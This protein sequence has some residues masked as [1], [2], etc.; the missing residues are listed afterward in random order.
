MRSDD[1]LRLGRVGVRDLLPEFCFRLGVERLFGFVEDEDGSSALFFQI[2][3]F[4]FFGFQVE[5]THGR[6]VFF[7]REFLAEPPVGESERRD[8][9][10]PVENVEYVFQRGEVSLTGRL[11]L[12]H[13]GELAG[14]AP[15]S[16]H[17]GCSNGIVVPGDMVG[18]IIESWCTV[19]NDLCSGKEVEIGRPVFARFAPKAVGV[20]SANVILVECAAPEEIRQ[21]V[22][23]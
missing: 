23:G 18:T 14:F 20:A 19:G 12:G 2:G 3:R 22:H 15:V 16:A 6:G 10:S 1:D 11:L 8:A 4:E 13:F 7:F 17:H 9:R 5:R 21:R